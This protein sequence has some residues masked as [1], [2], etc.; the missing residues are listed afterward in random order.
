V[1]RESLTLAHGQ[2]FLICWQIRKLDEMLT[3]VKRVSTRSYD[4]RRRV[5]TEVKFLDSQV[6][7]PNI[8]NCL[9]RSIIL[10]PTLIARKLILVDGP[11]TYCFCIT[12]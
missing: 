6:L 10:I 1:R 5:D 2:M 12:S 11:R 4:N 9:S 7:T 3:P 8:S